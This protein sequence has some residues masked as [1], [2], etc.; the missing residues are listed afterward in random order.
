[1]QAPLCSSIEDNSRLNSSQFYLKMVNPIDESQAFLIHCPK[2]LRMMN[3]WTTRD[4][5]GQGL[6]PVYLSSV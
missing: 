5:Q 4:I 1:M 6:W 3:F 2:L